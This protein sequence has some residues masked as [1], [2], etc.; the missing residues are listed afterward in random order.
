MGRGAQGQ[1]NNVL[2]GASVP[3]QA[4]E[5]AEPEVVL[6]EGFA[7]QVPVE[8]YPHAEHQQLI[9]AG[10]LVIQI[11]LATM[12]VGVPEPKILLQGVLTDDDQLLVAASRIDPCRD[13]TITDNEAVY[14]RGQSVSEAVAKLRVL[15][16]GLERG[17]FHTQ[18]EATWAGAKKLTS[19][20]LQ[21]SILKI[22]KQRRA[23]AKT[24][25]TP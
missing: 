12:L 13:Q 10:D 1:T 6:K 15:R 19:D 5:V 7:E 4:T 20:A 23:F 2:Y 21:K 3:R 18:G 24:G 17:E 25:L 8:K 22:Q 14:Y 16:E 9:D 11:P